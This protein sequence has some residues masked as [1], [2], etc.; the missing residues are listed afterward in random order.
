MNE[1][2][3]EREDEMEVRTVVDC[4]EEKGEQEERK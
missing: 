2:R 3:R 4:M 1:L